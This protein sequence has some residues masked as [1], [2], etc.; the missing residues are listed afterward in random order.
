[1]RLFQ[2]ALRSKIPS[3]AANILSGYLDCFD[4]VSTK[5]L[6]YCAII[7]RFVNNFSMKTWCSIIGVLCGIKRQSTSL[8]KRLL[9]LW[10]DAFIRH[11]RSRPSFGDLRTK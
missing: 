4:R 3:A 9:G 11:M 1:M 5:Q 8:K 7:C 2:P 10:S 6:I